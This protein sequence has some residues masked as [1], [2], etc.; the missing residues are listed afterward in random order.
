MS[1]FSLM[2]I[3]TI[4]IG[5]FALPVVISTFSGSHAYVAGPSVECTKCH[6]DVYNELLSSQSNHTHANADWTE[7][8]VFDCDEC[9]TVSGIGGS[10]GGGHAAQRV[11]CGFCHN[12]TAYES[13]GASYENWAHNFAT[14]TGLKFKYGMACSDCHRGSPSASTM[15]L[16]WV[17]M[18]ITKPTAAHNPFYLNA[19]NDDTLLGGTEACVGCHTHVEVKFSKPLGGMNMT[20]DPVT[21]EF[22]KE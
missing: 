16:D 21:G 2:L 11:D 18:N 6:A 22:G 14:S 3:A 9:H 10:P 1:K 20:Y 15:F 8:Q 4:S 13:K 5:I 17:Y 12:K 7:K 19:L